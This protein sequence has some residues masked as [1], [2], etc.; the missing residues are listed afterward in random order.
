MRIWKILGIAGAP[1]VGKSIDKPAPPTVLP[2]AGAPKGKKAE[3]E[4]KNI[5]DVVST[6]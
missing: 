5:P 1:G 6:G 2:G 3:E 4:S